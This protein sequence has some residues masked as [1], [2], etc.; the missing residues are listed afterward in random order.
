M[1]SN[2]VIRQLVNQHKRTKWEEHLKSGNL[3]TGVSKLWSTIKDLS[4]PK[5]HD[6]RVEILFDDHA[7]SDP[8]KCACYFS[9]QFTLQLSTEE[10]KGCVTRRLRKM[11][12]D[13]A[14]LTFSDK[15]VQSH[16]QGEIV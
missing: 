7:S 13:C 14:S 4:N 2:F 10:V 1:D 11:S 12:K 8:K 3:L 9:R 16:Q 5:R 15:E 6:D